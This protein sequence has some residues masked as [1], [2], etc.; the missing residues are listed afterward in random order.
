VTETRGHGRPPDRPNGADSERPALDNF[1]HTVR[2]AAQLLGM[3]AQSPETSTNLRAGLELLSTT[4]GQT[5]QMATALIDEIGID[6]S[7]QLGIT[8]TDLAQM[9][10]TPLKPPFHRQPPTVEGWRERAAAEF[11]LW[12][13]VESILTE[14]DEGLEH[15]FAANADEHL[16]LIEALEKLR[17]R[18]QGEV[19]LLEATLLRLAVAVARWE[20][21][22]GK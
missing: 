2:G 19:K 7:D 9:N 6:L 14:D 21:S 20:Q 12:G 10:F 22:D 16:E 15:R 13:A 1:A 17:E 8:T 18:W 4:L 5:A 3:V 11:T